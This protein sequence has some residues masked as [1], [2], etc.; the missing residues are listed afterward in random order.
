MNMTQ[1]Q[2]VKEKLKNQIAER[3]PMWAKQAVEME[4]RNIRRKHMAEIAAMEPWVRSAAIMYEMLRSRGIDKEEAI[5]VTK[6]F[7]PN[8][9]EDSWDIRLRHSDEW[10]ETVRNF[11]PTPPT[12][13]S[14]IE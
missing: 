6:S 11:K 7:F 10:Q 13:E 14:L 12:P 9:S 2:E 8:Q 3:I 4:M 1:E 5:S